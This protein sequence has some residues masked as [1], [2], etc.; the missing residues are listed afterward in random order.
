MMTEI[1]RTAPIPADPNPA[2][3]Y[4]A[5][6]A[7]GSRRGMMQSLQVV[8]AVL[9]SD[10]ASAT[11]IEW[12]SV[13]YQHVAAV[14]AVLAEKYAPATANR[15]TSALRGVLKEAWRLGQLD[16]EEFA[17]AVDVANVKGEQL[18]AGRSL[19]ASEI[20]ALLPHARTGRQPVPEIPRSSLL[21]TGRVY[22]EQRSQVLMSPTSM[23]SRTASRFG[24]A[25][26]TKD[27]R[28]TCRRGSPAQLRHGSTCVVPK[29][30]DCSTPWPRADVSTSVGG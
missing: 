12:A 8:A 20:K 9:S 2:A 14:R 6:L 29:P 10:R 16:A 1:V 5:R 17:R 22:A 13:R 23:S 24:R 19:P 3:V 11:E 30:G 27:D 7:Q 21:C 15:H 4:I 28:C 25:K 18:P 26:G